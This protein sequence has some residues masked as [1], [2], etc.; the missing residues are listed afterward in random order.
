M[1]NIKMKENNIKDA[2][3]SVHHALNYSI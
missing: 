2:F 3:I 1:L